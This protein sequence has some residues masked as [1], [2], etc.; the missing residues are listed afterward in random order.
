VGKVSR[1]RNVCRKRYS[2][3]TNMGVSSE[4]SFIA[5]HFATLLR[6]QKG[7]FVQIFVHEIF[8]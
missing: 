4:K 7:L 3:S 8:G 5:A 2:K 6:I 1:P